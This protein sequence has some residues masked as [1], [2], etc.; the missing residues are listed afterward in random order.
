MKLILLVFLAHVVASCRARTAFGKR[1]LLGCRGGSAP[2]TPNYDQTTNY[3]SY[4]SPDLPPDLPQFQDDQINSPHHQPGQGTHQ[5]EQFQPFQSHDNIQSSYHAEQH[6]H[7]NHQQEQT[8]YQQPP[9]LP[10]GYDDLPMEMPPP[11]PGHQGR[12]MFQDSPGVYNDREE[13]ESWGDTP[14]D[15]G[16]DLSSFNKEY[17]LKGLARLYKKKILPLE[18]SSRYGHF[19]SPP[20]SPSDFVAPPMVLLLGQY[21]YVETI[22][23]R[24]YL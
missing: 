20:L 9:P 1:I 15:A 4:Q 22:T 6:S 19:H 2:Q 24:E 7:L 11:P 3:E 13:M 17:I 18:L 8:Q 5:G 14:N 21:R 23:G 16:M 12:S 10:H